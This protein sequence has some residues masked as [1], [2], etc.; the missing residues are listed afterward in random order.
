MS[1]HESRTCLDHHQMSVLT[2]R[3]GKKKQTRNEIEILK[4][5]SYKL[6][7]KITR[8]SFFLFW[9]IQR[10]KS[11][12]TRICAEKRL[13]YQS[14]TLTGSVTEIT[15]HLVS[16]TILPVCRGSECWDHGNC[17][18]KATNVTKRHLLPFSPCTNV[19]N[20]VRQALSLIH[21]R[22]IMYRPI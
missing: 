7:W 3:S 13:D 17:P 4:I 14:T 18:S 10:R 15:R 19:L 21:T 5:A 22:H 1:K 6:R 12:I 16:C 20:N 2:F 9:F 8:V 11:Y